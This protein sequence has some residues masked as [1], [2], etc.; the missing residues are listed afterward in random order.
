[1]VNLDVP[2]YR[3]NVVSLFSGVEMFLKNNTG[4]LHHEDTYLSLYV[5]IR[6]LIEVTSYL[7]SKVLSY[8]AAETSQLFCGHFM[9]L[10]RL[11]LTSMI[12]E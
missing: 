7:R 10:H 6:L 5:G 3:D 4:T 2:M 8:K 12:G 1:V 9:K 11:I